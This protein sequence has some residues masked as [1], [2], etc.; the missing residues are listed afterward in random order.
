MKLAAIDIGTNSIHMIIAEATSLRSFDIIERE[1]E[2]AK[3]GAGVFA[4]NYISDRAYKVGIE[5]ISRYVQLADR[6]GVDEIIT[7]ATSAIREAHNG[8]DFLD[9]VVAQT[10]L[11][12]RI[13]SGKEEAR[14][15]F[16]AVRNSI[17][18]EDN[19]ALV[20]DIGGGSTEAVVGGCSKIFFGDSMPLGVLRLLDMFQD[21][22]SVG[23]EGKGVLEAHI[24][25]VGQKIFEQINE[26][27]F[28]RVIGTSGTIRTM[29]EAALIAAGGESLHS[30][31]SEVVALK[32]IA[33]LSEKLLDL[34]FAE[35][36]EVEGISTK[37]ADAIHLG[38]VLLV[39][40]LQMAGVKEITLCDASLREGMIL[41][42]L[43]RH[44]EE[45]IALPEAKN[46]RHRKAANLV[47]KYESDWS[48]N[49]HVADLALQLFDRTK[50]IHKYGNYEREILE[51]ASLLHDI[52]QFISFRQHHK[53]SRYI[54]KQTDPRG[55]TDE[56]IL[57]IQHL[58]RYHCKAK[59]SK[60]HK[61]FRKL[62]KH[63]RRIITLLAGI[64]RIA[65][66]LNKT[67][68][69]RVKQISCQVTEKELEITVSGAENLEVE[70]WAARRSSEVLA[71]ALKRKVEIK[72]N[73]CLLK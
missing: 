19:K 50:A 54:I 64:L 30:V 9:E 25:F 44:T 7:A 46:L 61:R 16:L 22:G 69:Q 73:L 53:N 60:K 1:K 56:E 66:A 41:D 12:P 51:F 26:I 21:K 6:L 32:D 72:S 65:V 13:I 24:R 42:Y 11:C 5:T 3:L 71:D 49:C 38:G 47:Y 27:G 14:L 70:I 37:R 39:Q 55:F 10:G 2:M 29:G 20:L 68:N 18:L 31:N 34:D 67:K 57:L 15:I 35:R 52:G 63:H 8:E 48:E 62:D 4:S 58:V 33:S 45:V 43:E 40:L 23:T 36:A 17:A 28:D 59:P